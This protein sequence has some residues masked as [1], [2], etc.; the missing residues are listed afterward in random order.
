MTLGHLAMGHSAP[1]AWA[2]EA[3]TDLAVADKPSASELE[4]AIVP[5]VRKLVLAAAQLDLLP[6]QGPAAWNAKIEEQLAPPR[7]RE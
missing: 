4:L 6:A 5:A 3:K 2:E 1:A 7:R